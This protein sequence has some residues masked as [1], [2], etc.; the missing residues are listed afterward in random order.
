MCDP[1]DQSDPRGRCLMGANPLEKR[2]SES[3]RTRT[4]MLGIECGKEALSE[5]AGRWKIGSTE[6]SAGQRAHERLRPAVDSVALSPRLFEPAGA[7]PH[8]GWCGEATR[9]LVNFTDTST[10]DAAA[11]S[12]TSQLP[13]HGD[14][15]GGCYFQDGSGNLTQT[16]VTSLVFSED[17]AARGIKQVS[18]SFVAAWINAND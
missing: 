6:P 9:G 17:G 8:G 2:S 5:T 11:S 15:G 16:G 18:A 4:R 14:S 10:Y 3:K 1:R 12:P 13:W 7:D